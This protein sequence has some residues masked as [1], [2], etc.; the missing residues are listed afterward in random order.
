MANL[1][2]FRV[3]VRVG[4]N[5]VMTCK[6]RLWIRRADGKT[7]SKKFGSDAGKAFYNADGKLLKVHLKAPVSER[8]LG[9]VAGKD[10]VARAFLLE[11]VPHGMILKSVRRTGS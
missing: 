10:K 9:G 8:V 1:Y 2:D 6:V 11:N 3:S 4:H 5:D 7:S